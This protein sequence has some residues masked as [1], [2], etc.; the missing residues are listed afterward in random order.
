MRFR[1]QS[2]VIAALALAAAT[3][4]A[5]AATIP[6]TTTADAVVADRVTSL[7]EAFALAS[8]NAQDDVITLQPGATYA[9]TL[10]ASGAL[11]HTASDDLTV[12]GAGGTIS[13]TCTDAPVVTGTGPNSLLT[14]QA[15][16]L[17]GG[18]GSGASI[19]GAGVGTVG[20]MALDGVTV[21]GVDAGTG[22]SVL[23]STGDDPGIDITLAGSALTGNAAT[24]I[25]L[26]GGGV[27]VTGSVISGNAGSGISMADGSPLV[28]SDSEVS[29]NGRLGVRTTGMGTTT[30]TLVDTVIADNGDTGFTCTG[31]G[32]IDVA[33]TTIEGNGAA[34]A[35]GGGGGGVYWTVDQDLGSMG[36]RRFDMTD[37]I[38]RDNRATRAGGGIHVG[39]LESSAPAAPSPVLA[40]T[41]SGIWDNRTE[42]SAA[43]GGGIHMET[44]SLAMGGGSVVGNRAGV[45]GR[46]GSSPGG[47]I[48]VAEAQ[49]DAITDPHDVQ[50][51]GVVFD[52]NA[53]SGAGGALYVR[54]EGIVDLDGLDFFSNTASGRG[55]AI[56]AAAEIAVRDTL[57]DDNS[58][59]RGGAVY[60]TRFG[61]A[62]RLSV[63]GSTFTSNFASA[64]GG[65]L[66]IDD[67]RAAAVVRS[68]FTGNAAPRGG[69]VQIG[70]DP[71]DEPELLRLSDVTMTANPSPAG[72]A[73]AADEGQLSTRRV[74][75]A[76]PLGGP[77]CSIPPGSVSPLGRSFLSDASC[78]AHA[79]DVVSP[80][81]PLLGP[82]GDNGGPTPTLV[83][84][85]GSPVRN[86]IA[87]ADCPPGATDQR[88]VVRPQGAGCEPG[89]V[90][91]GAA[92]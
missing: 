26:D 38:V 58:A 33:G 3:P 78:G 18:P 56:D 74:L 72:S 22:G 8:G 88:G 71:M 1:R 49:G 68:T 9:L 64:A 15:L 89:A 43:P 28:I 11:T 85:V 39:I 32:D 42:G 52:V 77:N 60:A 63:A 44:G 90:E 76:A 57:F 47:G 2:L 73:I 41:G 36:P 82:L 69:A 13:Q 55:G 86:L 92:G 62:G 37:S 12:A 20:R 50:L 35:P 51:A 5:G 80:A 14:L 17:D 24:G 23:W 27:T 70:I 81:S 53:A 16:A 79:T 67:T 46:P 6:V 7:R 65:A 34:A 66:M 59:A 29:G 4:V 10:C 75:I 54:T 84:G 61:R 83:P 48:F 21:T 91:V 25:N 45:G 87:V 40:I 31:C 30:V 19:P